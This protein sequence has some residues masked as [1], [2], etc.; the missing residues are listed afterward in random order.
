MKAQ[1]PVARSMLNI[2]THANKHLHHGREKAMHGRTRSRYIPPDHTYQSL[3]PRTPSRPSRTGPYQ[4][5]LNSRRTGV[6]GGTSRR[7]NTVSVTKTHERKQQHEE[8]SRPNYENWPLR[9]FS[10]RLQEKMEAKQTKAQHSLSI[11]SLERSLNSDPTTFRNAPQP[12][13]AAPAICG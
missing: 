7:V 5:R 9:A 8:G 10:S 12:N 13:T 6:A 2:L 4:S 3:H 1:D 11:W